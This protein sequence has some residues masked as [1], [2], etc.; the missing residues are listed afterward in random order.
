MKIIRAVLSGLLAFL[1]VVVLVIAGSYLKCLAQGIVYNLSLATP[2]AIKAGVIPGGAIF[3][4]SLIG[5][6]RRFPPN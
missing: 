6:P 2:L 3:L 1:V 5:A 4:L